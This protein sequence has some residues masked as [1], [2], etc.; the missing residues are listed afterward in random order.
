MTEEFAQDSIN[1]GNDFLSGATAKL[2]TELNKLIPNDYSDGRYSGD[3][4]NRISDIAAQ[5]HKG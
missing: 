2:T 1:R 4:G 3:V 5:L